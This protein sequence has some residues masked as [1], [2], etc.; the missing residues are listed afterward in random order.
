MWATLG[1]NVCA[2][3]LMFYSFSFASIH[4]ALGAVILKGETSGSPGK[5]V[6]CAFQ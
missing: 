1:E 6:K 4:V 5:N 3:V 2:S